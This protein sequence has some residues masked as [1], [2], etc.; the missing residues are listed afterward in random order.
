LNRT[1]RLD[2]RTFHPSALAPAVTWLARGGIVAFPT[3]TLYG[4]AVDPFSPD[5]VAALFDLKGRASHAAIPL[6]A[7]SRAQVES[8]FGRMEGATAKATE[9][10]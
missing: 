6:L 5:A 2:P 8:W 7:A 3:D 1:L 4:L 10:I 9:S